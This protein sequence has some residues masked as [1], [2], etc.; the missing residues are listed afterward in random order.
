MARSLRNLSATSLVGD[1]LCFWALGMKSQKIP[2]VEG[3]DTAHVLS[4]NADLGL[5]AAISSHLV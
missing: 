4:E 1:F 2:E 5:C 3:P